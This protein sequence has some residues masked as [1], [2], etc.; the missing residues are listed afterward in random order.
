MKPATAF[1]TSSFEQTRRGFAQVLG[2]G[3]DLPEVFLLDGAYSA[4]EV[5][6]NGTTLWV[7]VRADGPE[8]HLCVEHVT[9]GL[10]CLGGRA[11]CEVQGSVTFLRET[12]QQHARW[13]RDRRRNEHPD[14]CRV[15]EAA[16]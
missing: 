10:A 16:A 14:W 12:P 15:H 7:S 5:L 2:L 1:P 3:D 8:A 11:L 4:R 13:I 9:E 6:P